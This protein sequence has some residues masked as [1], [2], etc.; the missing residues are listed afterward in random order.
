MAEAQPRRLAGCSSACSFHLWPRWEP[1]VP[2]STSLPGAVEVPTSLPS[3]FLFMHSMRK[4]MRCLVS[5][6]PFR[7]YCWTLRVILET[8]DFLNESKNKLFE[9]KKNLDSWHRRCYLFLFPSSC[10]SSSLNTQESGH[11]EALRA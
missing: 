8:L 11:S 10:S 2:P 6:T 1:R 9:E 3:I 5:E 4:H 7:P